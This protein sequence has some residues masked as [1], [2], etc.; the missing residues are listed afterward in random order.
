MLPF[1]KPILFPLN[2][3]ERGPSFLQYFH[4][5]YIVSQA[6]LSYFLLL[7]K[8]MYLPQDYKPHMGGTQF[9]S[10]WF[11]PKAAQGPAD[12]KV[13]VSAQWMN[14]LP[15]NSFLKKSPFTVKI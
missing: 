6:A 2:S 10:S 14:E 15:N 9:Y 12:N 5:S 13:S 7:F 4:I 8:H 3:P 1:V 11:I